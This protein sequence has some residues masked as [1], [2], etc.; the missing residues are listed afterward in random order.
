[1]GARHRRG[2]AG[3]GR[4]RP[5]RA[6]RPADRRPDEDGARRGDGGALGRRTSRSRPRRWSRRAAS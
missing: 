3:P 5:A 1:V 6:Y 2:P 4:E